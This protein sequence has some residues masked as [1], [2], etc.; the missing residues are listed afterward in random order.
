MYEDSEHNLIKE[1]MSLPTQNYWVKFTYHKNKN[2]KEKLEFSFP[3]FDSEPT[4]NHTFLE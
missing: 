2:P 1:L 3:Q 4:V